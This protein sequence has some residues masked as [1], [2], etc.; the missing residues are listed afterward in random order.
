M[1]DLDHYRESKHWW[2]CLKFLAKFPTLPLGC[3]REDIDLV[4][5]KT[6]LK[7]LFF[8]HICRSRSRWGCHITDNGLYQIASARCVSNLNS[9]SLWGMTAITDSGVVQLVI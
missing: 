7:T 8:F 1:E 4:K 9:V 3:L 2:I 6:E 5:N